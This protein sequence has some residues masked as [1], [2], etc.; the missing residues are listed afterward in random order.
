VQRALSTWVI[1]SWR[2]SG[3]PA[4]ILPLL[5]PVEPHNKDAKS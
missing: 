4:A 3:E 1:V 5:Q 2:R